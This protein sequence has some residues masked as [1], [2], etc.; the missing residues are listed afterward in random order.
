MLYQISKSYVGYTFVENSV[1]DPELF[2]YARIRIR[3]D[4]A[5]I[6]LSDHSETGSDPQS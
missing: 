3:N 5:W 2:L 4:T 6:R 1:V